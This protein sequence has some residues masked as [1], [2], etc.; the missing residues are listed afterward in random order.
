MCNGAGEVYQV[1]RMEG[2]EF[3][4]FVINCWGMKRWQQMPAFEKMAFVTMA[5]EVGWEKVYEAMMKSV[6]QG[7]EKWNKA[8]IAGTLKGMRSDDLRAGLRMTSG[9]RSEQVVK[10]RYCGA[11]MDE[12]EYREHK[13]VCAVCKGE[14]ERLMREAGEEIKRQLRGAVG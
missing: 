3:D 9:D 10:K 7:P 14:S 13:Q 12:R 1:M 6:V 2:S 11:E 4:E 8:Y 5:R